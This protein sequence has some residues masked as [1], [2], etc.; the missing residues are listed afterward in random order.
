VDKRWGRVRETPTEKTRLIA[1]YKKALTPA[2]LS[3]A[4]RT[5]GRAIFQKQC[6]NCHKLFGVGGAIGP[7]LTGSQ[8]TNIDYLL[9]NIVDPSALISKEFHMEVIETSDGRVVTGMIVAETASAITVQTTNEKIV[10]PTGE[11]ERRVQ[12]SVSMM[13]EGQLANLNPA[14]VRDLFAYL[15]GAQQPA[16]DNSS[17]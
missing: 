8:R 14:E 15:T 13:P 10:I 17:R 3:D 9:L 7:D 4:D 2:A 11:V 6:A 1:S 12:S 5:A 16:S